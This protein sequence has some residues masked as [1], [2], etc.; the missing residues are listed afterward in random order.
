MSAE[1]SVFSHV[2]EM[3]LFRR[4]SDS[5]QNDGS[6]GGCTRISSGGEGEIFM[7]IKKRLGLK[8]KRLRTTVLK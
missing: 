7:F 8:K 4:D 5:Q 2:K 1:G 6:L 3:S